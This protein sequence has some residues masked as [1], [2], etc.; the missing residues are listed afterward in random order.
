MNNPSTF[1]PRI[2]HS[3]EAG[4]QAVGSPQ[5]CH[6]FSLV[7]LLVAM[8][9]SLF[10]IGG[11]V[12]LFVQNKTSYKLQEG[13]AR[14][15]ENG[16][17]ALL[18]M[19]K[20]IRRA[21]HPW[22]ALP[23]I[24]GFARNKVSSPAFTSGDTE[25]TEGGTDPDSLVIQYWAPSS[26]STDCVGRNIAASEYVAMNFLIA[27]GGLQCQSVATDPTTLGS[28]VLI[29]DITNLQITYGVDEDDNSIPDGTYETATYLGTDDT[30]WKQVVSVRIAVTVPV[31][32]AAL[33]DN[34]EMTFSTTVP[35]RNQIGR[36]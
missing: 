11:V 9:I 25:P 35:I 13:V 22:D 7:E 34:T 19:E 5:N 21:A 32:P 18:L 6:G 36:D 30:K 12:Q 23:Q 24:N 26:G 31:L 3:F 20:Q 15:Q 10:L 1:T 4:A 28:A 16:R 27:D 17:L 29:T 2:R 33:S 8:V 14:A